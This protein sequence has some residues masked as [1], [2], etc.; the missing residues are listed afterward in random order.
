MKCVDMCHYDH[1]ANDFSC[2]CPAN[3]KLAE[4]DRGCVLDSGND[5]GGVFQAPPLTPAVTEGRPKVSSTTISTTTT[6]ATTTSQS[7]TA[8]TTTAVPTSTAAPPPVVTTS[9]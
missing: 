4:D 5:L 1:I 7:T 3:F 8:S 9:K 2:T 6:E